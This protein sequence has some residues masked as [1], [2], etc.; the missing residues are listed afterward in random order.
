MPTDIDLDWSSFDQARGKH[1][2]QKAGQQATAQQ[3]A[4]MAAIP[5]SP[6][7]KAQLALIQKQA[8]LQQTGTLNPA[9]VA[10]VNQHY[11]AMTS[12]GQGSKGAGGAKAKKK[13]KSKSGSKSGSKRGKKS[14]AQKRA[15]AHNVA[16]KRAAVVQRKLK[17]ALAKQQRVYQKQLAQQMQQMRDMQNELDAFRGKYGEFVHPTGKPA[18]KKSTPKRGK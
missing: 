4:A 11:T 10:Y 17:V 13:A 8:G 5:L 3:Q 15:K 2:R 12:G 14:T 16:M 9:T 18:P 1:P 6:Q 7:A